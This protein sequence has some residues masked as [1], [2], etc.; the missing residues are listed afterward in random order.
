MQIVVR[1]HNMAGK[2]LKFAGFRH[3]RISRN[4]W[5][6]RLLVILKWIE[7]LWAELTNWMEECGM[8][9]SQQMSGWRGF[10]NVA[11]WWL[12][13]PCKVQRPNGIMDNLLMDCV[14]DLF[15]TKVWQL[16]SHTWNEKNHQREECVWM[17]LFTHTRTCYWARM[18]APHTHTHAYE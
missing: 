10:G 13:R 6:C 4:N 1:R 16:N 9:T 15:V 7:F 18:R 12:K 17:H 3:C 5:G 11:D 8:W 2:P 14:W